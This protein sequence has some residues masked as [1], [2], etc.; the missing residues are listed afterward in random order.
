VTRPS[1]VE[2]KFSLDVGGGDKVDAK[3]VRFLD[4]C[5]IPFNFLCSPYCHA[6]IKAV[7][8]APK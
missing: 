3:E 2:S 8:N 1:L 4:T 6:M 7:H 5:D